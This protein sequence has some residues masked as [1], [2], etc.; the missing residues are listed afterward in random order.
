MSLLTKAKAFINQDVTAEN[1]A[2]EMT[3]LIR[4]LT[5]MEIIGSVIFAIMFFA[6]SLP[7]TSIFFLVFTAAGIGVMIATYHLKSL[8]TMV[9]HC[10]LILAFVLLFG[11]RVDCRLGIHY[12]AFPLIP[13]VFYRAGTDRVVK[14]SVTVLSAVIAMCMSLYAF[15]GTPKVALPLALAML[16]SVLNVLVIAVKFIILSLFYYKKFVKDESKIVAYSR[17]L[18]QLAGA[19]ALTGLSNRRKMMDHLNDMAAKYPTRNEPFSVA[20]ADIDFFK[21]VNDTYGHEAGDYV[22]T[23]IAAIF[24]NFMA[25]KGTP[26]RW[27]GEEFLLVFDSMNG[28]E[29][30]VELSR[31]RNQIE[32]AEF[33]YKSNTISITMTF[34]LEEYDCYAGIQDTI[35]HAD[36]KLYQGKKQG[37]NCVIY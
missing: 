36:E 27:G 1:E 18:E 22:L 6:F 16:C 11:L 9:L 15:L 10:L 3:V 7:G 32:K 8:P 21:A 24:K 25:G 26:A 35:A 34:G 19:D 13:L 17:K 37:R 2:K 23:S 12:A 29:V 30:F 20:I 33:Q 31:L 28:D 14:Y 5:A 4:V